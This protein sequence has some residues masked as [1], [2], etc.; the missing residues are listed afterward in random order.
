MDGYTE[1]LCDELDATVFSGDSL[2]DADSIKQFK[3]FLGRWGREAEVI[4][5]T[6]ETA[7]RKIKELREWNPTSMHDSEGPCP[8]CQSSD[9]IGAALMRGGVNRECNQCHVRWHNCAF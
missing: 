5:K 7:E 2:H 3:E 8:A 9:T 1:A 4:E 6:L